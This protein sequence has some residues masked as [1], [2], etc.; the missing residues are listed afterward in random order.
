MPDKQLERLLNEKLVYC[1][2]KRHGCTWSGELGKLEHNHLLNENP[3]A[4]D[5]LVG[6]CL[7]VQ[8]QSVLNAKG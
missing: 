7:Y 4:P 8:I 3:P 6:G 1:S 5:K 2:N